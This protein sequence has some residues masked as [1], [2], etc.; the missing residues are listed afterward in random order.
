MIQQPHQAAAGILHIQDVD[1][2]VVLFHRANAGQA[3]AEELAAILDATAES[4][5]VFDA[6]GNIHAC[7]RSAE[8]LF[9]YDGAE[10]VR[11]NLAD[12]FG[13]ESER[14]VFE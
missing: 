9:G 14:V 3:S 8:A 6:E 11:R 7:N 4:V 5:I 10:L 13:P 12:L 1:T 2:P